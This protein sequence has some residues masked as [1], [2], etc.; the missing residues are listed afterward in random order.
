M[1]ILLPTAKEMNLNL[2]ILPPKDQ[3]RQTRQISEVMANQ[4]VFTLAQHYK[5]KHELAQVE[6]ERWQ[7]L[8]NQTANT[9]TAWQ[10]FDGLMYRQMKR[11]DLSIDWERYLKEHVFI[12]SALYGLINVF[13]PIAPHRLDFLMGFKIDG[14]SLKTFWRQ[15]FDQTVAEDEL[16]I[17]LLSSEFET[18]FSKNLQSKMIKC[19]FMEEKSGQLKVHSTISKKAR[20]KFLNA[21]VANQ[22]KDTEALKSLQFDG[23]SYRSELSEGNKLV[24]I[25]GNRELIN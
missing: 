9:Y 11:Q 14:Q 24:F 22:V 6:K 18:V 23:F 19:Q 1:K 2:P 10:L 7:D 5:L 20:G 21:L 13:E 17:S 12:T 25:K 16:I 8:H 3:S 15:I 4:S